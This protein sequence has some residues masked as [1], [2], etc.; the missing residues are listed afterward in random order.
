MARF[1]CCMAARA[2]AAPPVTLIRFTSRCLNSVS[3]DS[4]VGS[5]DDAQQVVDAKIAVDR[6]VVAAHALGGHP[7]S[8]GCGLMTTV[9]PAEIIL[10][11]LHVIVGSECVTGVMAQITPNGACSMTVRP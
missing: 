6:L 5:G 3:A 7:P 9:L 1:A 4:S 2:T 8:A 11:A 10:I